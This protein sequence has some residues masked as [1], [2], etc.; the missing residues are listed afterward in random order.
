M[1]LIIKKNLEKQGYRIIG[2]NSA[3]KIC[4]WTKKAMFDKGYCY[5]QQFYGIN[6]HRCCQMTPCMTCSNSC[7]FCWRDVD[8]FN[9]TNY[10]GDID[11]PQEIIDGCISAQRQLI[12]GYPGNSD[13]NKKKFKEAQDPLHFAISLS[14]EPSLY[15]KLSELIRSLKKMKK[16]SFLVS[17]GMFPKQLSSLEEPTQF[18]LSLDAPNKKLYKEIDRPLFSDYWERF[19]SSLELMKS[20]GKRNT[21]RITLVKGLNDCDISGYVKLIEKADP[22][23]VE[24]KSYMFVGG[25]RGRLV[26]ENMPLFPDVLSFSEKLSSALGMKIVDSKKESRVCLL[27]HEDSKNRK[28]NFD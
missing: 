11:E 12:N 9:N 7:L 2:S 5:K 3:C 21:L 20:F 8:L 4:T 16:S 19:N 23:F 14:G 26:M 25:S 13:L 6:S 27:M 22:K 18:Y 24:V 1:D 28:L 17:N 15:P 10:I